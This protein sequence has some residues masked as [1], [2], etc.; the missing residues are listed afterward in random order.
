[1]YKCSK[2]GLSVIVYNGKVIRACVC[3]EDSRKRTFI[4]KV[5]IFFNLSVEE[6]KRDAH[7]IANVYV[8][9]KGSGIL[10]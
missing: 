10:K 6:I 7:I 5:R 9:L 2:C 8:N 3:K 1:M 4:E